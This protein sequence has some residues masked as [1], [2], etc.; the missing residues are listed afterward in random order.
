[1]NQKETVK[2]LY[3]RRSAWYDRL[4]HFIGYAASRKALLKK[5]QLDLS[6]SPRVLDLG[7]GTGLATEALLERFP[8]A[9]IVAL[10]F[11]SDMLRI[12]HEKFPSTKLVV[13]DFNNP[14]ALQK[15]KLGKFELIISTGAVSEY[16]DYG[17][18][19]PFIHNSLKK[20]GVFLAIGVKL[21][22]IG[23]LILKGW[24]T[25]PSTGKEELISASKKVFS[26]VQIIPIPWYLAPAKLTT[27]FLKAVK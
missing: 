13:G 9:K 14:K 26:K 15:L 2:G 25:A 10:D 18:V 1:M 16:G 7:A 20:N 11:S 17:K 23:K 8:T 22:F 5:I 21:N 24:H 3:A 12:Y 4:I 27:Y 19:M 6:S